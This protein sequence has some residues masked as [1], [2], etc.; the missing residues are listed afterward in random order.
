[1]HDRGRYLSI[2]QQSDSRESRDCPARW[3]RVPSIAGS[4]HE[5]ARTH[6]HSLL[7][8]MTGRQAVAS[9]A[10]LCIAALVV[11]QADE[12]LLGDEAGVQAT[13]NC[14]A[15]LASAWSRFV[16]AS[17]QAPLVQLASG[18]FQPII[19]GGGGKHVTKLTLGGVLA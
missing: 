5:L 6:R 18:T 4:P 8:D 1:M 9:L 17:S 19:G 11:A 12:A 3:L 10:L 16:H 7:E 2:T 13:Y 14:P 15:A